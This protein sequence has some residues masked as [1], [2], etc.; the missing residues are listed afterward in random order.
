[1][2]FSPTSRLGSGATRANLSVRASRRLF[3]VLELVLVLVLDGSR[4]PY[5]VS[6]IPSLP[7]SP[8]ELPPTL[9]QAVVGVLV[10]Q[11][12]PDHQG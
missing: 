10:D 4:I 9:F 12:I 1:M 3:L 5:S 8:L 2:W 7:I 11:R 6:R